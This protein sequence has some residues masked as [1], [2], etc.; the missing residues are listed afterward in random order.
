VD[1]GFYDDNI[2]PNIN[3]SPEEHQKLLFQRALDK[4]RVARATGKPD[5]SLTPEELQAYENKLN[6][7]PAPAARQPAVPQMRPS[8]SSSL[9][10]GRNI[11]SVSPARPASGVTAGSGTGSAQSSVAARPK[12]SRRSSLFGSSRTKTGEKSFQRKRAPSVTRSEATNQAPIQPIH[13]APPGFMVPGPNGQPVYTPINSYNGRVA[14]EAARRYSSPSRPGSR[15]ASIGSYHAATPPRDMPGG[16]PGGSA[17]VTA[18]DSTPPGRARPVSVPSHQSIPDDLDTQLPP[19]NRSRSGSMQQG[20][21]MI[22][23]PI[24]GYPYS[25]EPYSYH[26]PAVAGPTAPQPQTQPTAPQPQYMGRRVVSSSS[27]D[28]SFIAVPRRVPVPVQRTNAPIV[29]STQSDPVIVTRAPDEPAEGGGVVVDVVPQADGGYQV[30]STSGATGS[31]VAS[32]TGTSPQ[33]SEQRRRSGRSTR[34]R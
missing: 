34:R 30:R 33:G 27:A 9:P 31:A 28:N 19:R 25:S 32:S 11:T 26:V 4:I 2:G 13:Q 14:R 29:S 3:I 17:R 10:A 22:S 20:G 23:F 5:V 24:T 6:G 8:S 7:R 1:E 18:R 21:G 15:S 12:R 16:F